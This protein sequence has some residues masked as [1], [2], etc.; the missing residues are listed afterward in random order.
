MELKIKIPKNWDSIT[1]GRFA[2]LYPVLTSDGKLVEGVPALISVLSGIPLDDIKKS[3]TDCAGL[4]RRLECAER[5]GKQLQKFNFTTWG[6]GIYA[7][8]GTF[9]DFF[10]AV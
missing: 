5:I 1:V 6:D 2:E 4:F 9:T 7:S 10:F 3:Q 8:C